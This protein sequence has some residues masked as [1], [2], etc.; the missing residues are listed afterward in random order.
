MKISFNFRFYFA[1]H[2]H[3]T[4]NFI[5]H[6]DNWNICDIYGLILV[7]IYLTLAVVSDFNVTWVG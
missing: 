7:R 6:Y 5:D 2:I 4:I 3:L 1:Y